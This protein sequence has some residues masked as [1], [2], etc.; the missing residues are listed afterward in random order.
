MTLKCIQH[1]LKENLL[2]LKDLLERGRARFLSTRLLFQ[3]M[4]I[5]ILLDDIV[6]KYN[7]TVHKTIKM[8][9]FEVTSDFYVNTIKIQMKK[10]LIAKL[11][12]MSKFQNTKTFLLKDTLQIGY[13]M[14]LLLAKLKIQFRGFMLLVT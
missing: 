14:F 5:L 2:L 12:I 10:I 1:T 8:K 3:R 4:F 6:N 11:V 13:N 9:P 7:S